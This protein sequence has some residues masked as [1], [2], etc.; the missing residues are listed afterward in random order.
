MGNCLKSPTSD[1]ISLLH[2][3]QSDRASFG[4]G[5]DPD[6]EPPP[7]YQEPAHMPLYHPTPSQTRLASQLT[8]EEQ[9]R[10]AQRIGLIQ[11][12]PKGVFDGGPDGSEK[13]IRECV[14]CML[15]FV[16]GDPIRFLP[17]MHIYHMDC[18]DDWLMRSF[19]CPSCMEPVDAAL[20]STYETN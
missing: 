20:L 14:I 6:L 4:D 10:I 18:I 3:S 19:T 12:L 9:I 5:I 17:C 7:P 11:H 16:Y 1:D 13:K 8:E 15:D 2:E